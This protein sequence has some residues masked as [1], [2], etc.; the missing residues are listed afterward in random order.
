MALAVKVQDA[1]ER[2]SWIRKM[3]EEG[4]RLKARYGADTVFDFSLGNPDLEPP[5][6]FGEAL[7]SVVNELPAGAHG[8]MPNAGYEETRAAVA[9][10]VS[11]VD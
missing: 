9:S 7:R 4:A 8:Y 5:A 2:S 3:F 1:I 10:Y 6:R 11:R